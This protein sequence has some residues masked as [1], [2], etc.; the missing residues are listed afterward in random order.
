MF[1]H[2]YTI[3]ES[4][5]SSGVI[6]IVDAEGTWLNPALSVIDLGL[7]ETYNKNNAAVYTTYQCYLKVK[8]RNQMKGEIKV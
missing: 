1:F 6:C 7:M 4:C 8:L 2:I 5:I 3:A